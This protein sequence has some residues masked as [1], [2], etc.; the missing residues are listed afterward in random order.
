MTEAV[1]ESDT[2]IAAAL[3]AESGSLAQRGHKRGG[4]WSGARVRAA[5]PSVCVR[6]CSCDVAS[7]Q[8]RSQLQRRLRTLASHVSR[9]LVPRL[10]LSSFD[11]ASDAPRALRLVE[12]GHARAAVLRL[13]S[14]PV[15]PAA[16]V[17][18]GGTSG[19]GLLT[20]QWLA[21]TGRAHV[22]LVSRSAALSA[23]GRQQLQSAGG[24]S[25]LLRRCDVAQAA[26][27]RA[28][29]SALAASLPPLRGVFHSA[30]TLADGLL[31]QQ[32][33]ARLRRVFA[34]KAVGAAQLH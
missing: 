6:D 33:A 26:E 28:L 20:A 27:T 5:A 1:A 17:V 10:P 16:Y 4:A 13:P 25:W 19:L 12:R 18:T 7:A 3:L 15:G 2:A 9:A 30:G 24:G 11:F 31:A 8:G 34:P 32:D 29:G 23:R 22:A 21:H 14:A